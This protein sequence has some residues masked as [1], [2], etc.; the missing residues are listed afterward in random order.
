MLGGM[1]RDLSVAEAAALLGISRSALSADCAA[2][3]VPH[4]RHGMPGSARPRYTLSEEHVAAIR[5]VRE[6]RV[7]PVGQLSR[8]APYRPSRRSSRTA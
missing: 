7:T 2:R 5:A 8:S 4:F 1:K 6:V 3:R